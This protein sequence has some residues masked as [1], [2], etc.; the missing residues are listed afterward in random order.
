MQ[1]SSC[2]AAS[3]PQARPLPGSHNISYL[4]RTPGCTR[5]RTTAAAPL[6]IVG[7]VNAIGTTPGTRYSFAR[8]RFGPVIGAL[9]LAAAGTLFWNAV[10][11]LLPS[12][13]RTGLPLGATRL[14]I[15][16]I[17]LYG[18]WQGLTGAGFGRGRRLAVWLVMAIPLLLWQSV[19]WWRAL[20]GAF[21][22]GGGPLLLAMVLPLL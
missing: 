13:S 5:G 8:D 14:A 18:A 15:L 3:C 21:Q 16:A 12:L 20:A 1:D 19:A 11:L 22:S 9:V 6:P 17:I 7:H 10:N 4:S 2:R